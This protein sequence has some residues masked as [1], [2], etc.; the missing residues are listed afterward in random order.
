MKPLAKHRNFGQKSKFCSKSNVLKIE[1]LNKKGH[2]DQKIVFFTKSKCL[3]KTSKLC[4][5]KHFG[6]KSKFPPNIE[7]STKNRNFHQKSKFPP[8]IEISTKNRNFHQKSK[9]PPKI[10]I[11]TFR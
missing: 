8:K 3:V 1:T 10:E 4:S 2:F 5:K 11:C 6:P 7:I 9:F